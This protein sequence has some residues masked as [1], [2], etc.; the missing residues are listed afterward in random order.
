M[1]MIA[2]IAIGLWGYIIVWPPTHEWWKNRYVWSALEKP[3][4]M[5]FSKGV[6][7]G[8]LVKHVKISTV[9][10]NLPNG[11]PL[12]IEPTD[13]TSA[14]LTM[15]SIVTVDRPSEPLATSLKETLSSLG[16]THRVE[17]GLL[18]IVKVKK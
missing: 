7:L 17:G 16:L 9:G 11:V 10:P 2:L 4:P 18:K 3:V 8:A 14:G 12:Y 5:P 1:G 13:L 6:P 15:G